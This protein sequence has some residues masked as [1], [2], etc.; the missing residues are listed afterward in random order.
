MILALK[1]NTFGFIWGAWLLSL[2]FKKQKTVQCKNAV[3]SRVIFE[4]EKIF[5]CVVGCLHWF[6]GHR[7]PKIQEDQKPSAGLRFL[8]Y[9][10]QLRGLA[11]GSY[12]FLEEMENVG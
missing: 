7:S 3:F 1:F 2:K 9:W 4:L 6:L 12:W 5:V 8:I 10:T 11:I